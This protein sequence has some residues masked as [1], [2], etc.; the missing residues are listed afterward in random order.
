M[1]IYSNIT[2]WS[3]RRFWTNTFWFNKCCSNS[4]SSS[5]EF[6]EYFVRIGLSFGSS[7]ER[8]V[9]W[10]SGMVPKNIASYR[11]WHRGMYTP[12]KAMKKRLSAINFRYS[13][14]G[15]RE[16][17]MQSGCFSASFSKRVT[18]F[19]IFQCGSLKSDWYDASVAP[20]KKAL[21]NFW[22]GVGTSQ[23]K[24]SG[25]KPIGARKNSSSLS[26]LSPK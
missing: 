4:S 16:G 24:K 19:S 12:G 14:S 8:V 1:S 7:K 10:H 2:S 15:I 9:V 18:R 25:C 5:K 20:T 23:E 13:F 26:S 3:D 6:Q 21:V 11:L 22:I 17:M